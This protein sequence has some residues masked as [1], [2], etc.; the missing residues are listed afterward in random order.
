MPIQHWVPVGMTYGSHGM[1]GRRCLLS[2]S[3]DISAHRDPSE[4][5]GDPGDHDLHAFCLLLHNNHNILHDNFI[6]SLKN[7][8][9]VSANRFRVLC[10]DFF[11]M[12]Y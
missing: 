7:M 2:S 11:V 10:C 6:A 5:S 8:A 9:K 4:T 1:S 12:I 3:L